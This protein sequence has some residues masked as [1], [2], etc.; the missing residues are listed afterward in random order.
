MYFQKA[1]QES[2]SEWSH[3]KKLIN[4]TQEKNIRRSIPKG[5]PYFHVDFGLS[6]GNFCVI[7]ETANFCQKYPKSCKM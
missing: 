6:H 3:N 2:E 1:I 7:S 5:L 4:L